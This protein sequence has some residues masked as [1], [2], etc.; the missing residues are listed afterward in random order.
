MNPACIQRICIARRCEAAR[1]RGVS[2]HLPRDERHGSLLAR[3]AER[4]SMSSRAG[5]RACGFH[6]VV[7]RL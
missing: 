6:I 2:I 7:R 5:S 1:A 3:V 4:P